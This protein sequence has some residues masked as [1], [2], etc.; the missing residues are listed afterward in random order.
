MTVLYETNQ[1]T[2]A[3][4]ILGRIGELV[5]DRSYRISGKVVSAPKTIEKGH[6]FLDLADPIDN[7]GRL[8]CA[9]FEPTKSFRGVVRKLL[10]GDRIE[11]WGSIRSGTLNMERLDILQLS[12]S[13]VPQAPS[14]PTCNRKM[15]SAGRD[16]G[17]RC[18]TCGTKAPGKVESRTKRDIE[19]GLYEVPPSA[20]R[21]LSK[22]LIRFEDPRAH[23]SR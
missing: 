2:D 9:A 8:V 17:Y 16:Q 7:V 14:C 10:P 1:G 19:V 15:K 21:H 5:E 6:V 22:P 23:P 4:I 3:H 18:R 11:V 20:R 13:A 12:S